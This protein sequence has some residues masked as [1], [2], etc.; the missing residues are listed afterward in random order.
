MHVFDSESDYGL[1]IVS[2]GSVFLYGPFAGISEN[3][4]V[5]LGS[6]RSKDAEMWDLEVSWKLH[7]LFS[8]GV[9]LAN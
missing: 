2:D 3:L 5:G 1:M 9:L 8:F 4:L 6:C 7:Y